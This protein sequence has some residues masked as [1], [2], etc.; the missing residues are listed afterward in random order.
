MITTNIVKLFYVITKVRHEN[1][2]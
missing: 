2:N 1:F